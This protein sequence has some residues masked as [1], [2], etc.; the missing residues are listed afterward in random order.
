MDIFINNQRLDISDRD[1]LNLR[2]N[3]IINNVVTNETKQSDYSFSFN[4]PCTPTNNIIFSNANEL[5]VNNKFNKIFNCIV[6]EDEYAIFTGQLTIASIENTYYTVNLVN[7]KYNTVSTIFEDRTLNELNWKIP[8][9]GISTINEYNSN[10][11]KVMFPLVNYGAFQKKPL[12]TEY[13]YNTYSNYF[14]ID[15]SNQ[16]FYSSFNPS[17]NLIELIK[18]MFNQYGYQL[19]G[20]ILKD[21]NLNRLY[22]SIQ[23][24]D[25]QIPI[26]NLGNPL[27][28]KVNIKNTFS[29]SGKSFLVHN[30]SYPTEGFTTLQNS[31]AT[32]DYNWND[33]NIYDM[34]LDGESTV[35][36]SYLF[37]KGDNSLVIPSDGLYKI[38]LDYT[39]SLD[40]QSLKGDWNTASG[41]TQVDLINLLT[42][43]MPV[44]IQLVR[45][46]DEDIELIKGPSSPSYI[47][48][49]RDNYVNYIGCYPHENAY[50]SKIATPYQSRWTTP[51]QTYLPKEWRRDVTSG[52]RVNNDEV[53][54]GYMPLTKRVM[55]VDSA[56]HSNFICGVTSFGNGCNGVI[57][58]GYGYS[59]GEENKSYYNVQYYRVTETNGS[60]K[61]TECDWNKSIINDIPDDT[62]SFIDGR[63]L[64]G[65]IHL[66][67]WL[68]RNDILSLKAITKN[69]TLNDGNIVYTFNCTTD[70][71]IEAYNPVN[72]VSSWN[73]E[74]KFDKEL[75]L[76]N[77]LSSNITMANF[78]NNFIKEF[79][80][81][82]QQLD[83]TV[84]INTQKLSNTRDVVELDIKDYKIESI[85]YPK[86]F[87]INY[88][89]DT[90]EYGYELT[91]PKDKINDNDWADYG[92]KHQY[93]V[94][95]GGTEDSTTEL[96]DSWCYF[97]TF[98]LNDESN[99]ISI[100]IIQKSEY[101]FG[102][103]D[104]MMK[105]DGKSLPFRY[106]IKPIES[107]EYQLNCVG[108]ELYRVFIPLEVDFNLTDTYFNWTKYHNY[109]TIDYPLLT[110]DY[111]RILKGAYVRFDKDLYRVAELQGFGAGT[112]KIKLLK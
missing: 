40:E 49:N 18:R 78:I 43:D 54:Y 36:K 7:I 102:D 29:N 5:A 32:T 96:L 51:K 82:Y 73:D 34:W 3:N 103:Y 21:K 92:N 46:T 70:F 60:I 27:L 16:W 30:L 72:S 104:E 85:D 91:V 41:E 68:E 23:L 93:K 100:P 67:I 80:L 45:N 81:S 6:Y 15:S 10:G 28:G 12:S 105:H 4:I 13:G 84:T 17:F 52:H 86:A 47:M 74:S 39:I 44:E 33:I 20:N 64:K 101:I 109:V 1:T 88:N 38:S 62:L 106:W 110:R 69:W 63:T 31:S 35:S 97:T 50:Q 24:A 42:K 53:F 14:M 71:T 79:N 87:I 111:F 77:F 108:G 94:N 56:V 8:F 89:I 19:S 95:L 48:G 11:E 99:Q 98:S 9:N 107:E 57:K 25:D 90:D 26:Y 2:L 55:C 66:V 75:S 76:G 61:Y 37:T 83:S 112:T 59:S 65:S 22:T 58:N